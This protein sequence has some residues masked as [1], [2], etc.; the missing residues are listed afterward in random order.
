MTPSRA[1]PP[2]PSALVAMF[3]YLKAETSNYAYC[4]HGAGL[5]TC[6]S[7]RENFKCRRELTSYTVFKPPFLPP[8]LAH[9]WY[10][11]A[12]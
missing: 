4:K 3:T 6:S 1:P 8:P 9:K 11:N 2:A 7:F 10:Y 5:R 12:C